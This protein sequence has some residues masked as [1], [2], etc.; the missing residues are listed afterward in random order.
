MDKLKQTG[1][2]W[3]PLEPIGNGYTA[4]LKNETHTEPKDGVRN[5]V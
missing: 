1:T 5:N 3:N 4:N 2:R